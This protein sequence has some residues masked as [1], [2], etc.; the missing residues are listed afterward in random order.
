MNVNEVLIDLPED[1]QRRLH[2]LLG[3]L[4]DESLY[5]KSHPEANPV[6][7]TT[8][9]MTRILDVFLTQN[10]EGLGAEA[11]IWYRYK[12]AEKTDC[13]PP[14]HQFDS[15]DAYRVYTSTGN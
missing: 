1:N 11:E 6:M 12:W 10:A 15:W 2:R 4:S 13:G 14:R 3:E 7:I 9:H 5:W 8:W